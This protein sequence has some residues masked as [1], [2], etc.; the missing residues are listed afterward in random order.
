MR[1]S[2]LFATAILVLVI[3]QTG[4]PQTNRSLSNR[5]SGIQFNQNLFPK[6]TDTYDLGS[7]DKKWKNLYLA[8]KEGINI[9]PDYPLDVYNKNYDIA[10]N[11]FSPNTGDS[12]DRVGVLSESI[13]RDNWGLGLVARGGYYGVYSYGYLGASDFV[14]RG[15]LGVAE[16]TSCNGGAVIGV[17]GLGVGASYNY[18]VVGEAYDFS[19]CGTNNGF[20]AAGFFTGDVYAVN[21]ISL[22]DRKFKTGITQLKSSTLLEQLMKLKP[23]AFEFKTDQYPKMGLP[24]G[25]QMG[26]TSDEVKQVFPEL[27]KPTVSPA[28]YDKD[29]KLLAKEEKYESVNYIGFIPILIAS[30]QEQ[31]KTIDAVKAENEAMKAENKELK[32]RLDKIEQTLALNAQTS[33]SFILSDARLE[34]NAPNPFNQNTMI[35]YSLPEKAGNAVINI[36]D[37]NGKVIKTVPLTEKG[38]GQLVLEAGQL[39]AGTYRY[40]LIVN[41]KLLDTKK[42]VLTK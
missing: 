39:A 4:L 19:G 38:K 15:V 8:G 25:K 11:A 16:G 37:M 26:F 21:F 36:T 33:S 1:T 13:I 28:R 3:S 17:H 27:V 32:S 41:G 12:A 30:V 18:G 42:M 34:Q 14:T 5:T 29:R 24:K 7:C 40:S 20:T 22:S 6:F 9:C 31:Q 10:I 23:S 2:K 35:N